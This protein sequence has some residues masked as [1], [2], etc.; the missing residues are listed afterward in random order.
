M[1]IGII[2]HG[3]VGHATAN[4]FRHLGHEVLCYDKDP[5][6]SNA[7]L[8][9]VLD[10]DIVFVCLPTPRKQG[11]LACDTS[12]LSDLWN[13]LGIV[14]SRKNFVLKSTVPVGYT[15]R[16]REEWDLPNLVHSPEFL[17][18][19]CAEHDAL[20]PRRLI[21]GVPTDGPPYQCRERLLDLYHSCWPDVPLF[22]MSSDESEAV[23]LF[24]NSFSAVKIAAFNEFRSL[25]DKLGLNWDEILGVL[26]AGGWINPMHTDV[27]GHD[28]KRG[29]GGSCLPKDLANLIQCMNDAEVDS[30]ICKAALTRNTLID[31]RETSDKE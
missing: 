29:F 27:P 3:V 25:A 30:I 8:Q 13:K 20:H 24:Q 11:E 7:S 17:T 18:A 2:G 1:K 14:T 6:R 19:R 15:R 10:C 4:A 23:K 12:A 31:R 22:R 9:F 21:V 26:L 16:A 5:A 28:G